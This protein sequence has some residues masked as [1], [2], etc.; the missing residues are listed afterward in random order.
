MYREDKCSSE[1]KIAL[2]QRLRLIGE[3]G[4][5]ASVDRDW[6]ELACLAALRVD[7]VESG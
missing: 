1:K 3:L 2:R 7:V 5:C 4:V 6:Q